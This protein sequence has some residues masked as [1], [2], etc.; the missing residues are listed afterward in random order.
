[1]AGRVLKAVRASQ[2]GSKC[3]VWGE[4][5]VCDGD[6]EGT[7]LAVRKKRRLRKMRE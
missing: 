7:R 1:M 6:G 2:E 4:E 3:R 5:G